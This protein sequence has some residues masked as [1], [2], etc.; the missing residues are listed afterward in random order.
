MYN[1]Q[2]SQFAK[3]FEGIRTMCVVDCQCGR[4]HFVSAAGHGD[5]SDGELERLL[6]LAEEQPDKYV[7]ET[8]YDYIDAAFID[9]KQIVPDCPCGQYKKY[10]DWIE[11]HAQGLARYLIE[12]FKNRARRAES[13]KQES[14]KLTAGL[15][16]TLT[17]Q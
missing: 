8:T 4:I 5:Y 3:A 17:I 9:G 7:N 13:I 12:H 2:Q 16:Q 15:G 1:D 14:E 6:K 11:S 10:C